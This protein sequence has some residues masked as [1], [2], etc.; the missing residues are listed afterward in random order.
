MV[1]GG[2]VC[3]CA[4]NKDHV[5]CF[6][7]S[8]PMVMIPPFEVPFQFCIFQMKKHCIGPARVFPI[9][10]S[11]FHTQACLPPGPLYSAKSWVLHGC[12]LPNR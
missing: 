2:C 10:D 4:V 1:G 6:A 12:H 11:K 5:R 3:V 9:C 8:L 7:Y